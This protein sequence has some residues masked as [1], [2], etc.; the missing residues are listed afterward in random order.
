MKPAYIYRARAV[1]AIDGDT[2]IANVDLGFGVEK[3]RP[4]ITVP[5]RIR[6]RGLFCAEV[7]KPWEKANAS[8]PGYQAAAALHALITD[9]PLIVQS[10]KD[11][12]SFE[13][14]VCD[15]WIEG[16]ENTVAEHMIADGKGT[17]TGGE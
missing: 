1:R 9:M 11:A 2:L 4:G 6:I 17:A 13:R 12:R 16:E 7:T 15:V 8:T 5:L 3:G 14:W 10:Y